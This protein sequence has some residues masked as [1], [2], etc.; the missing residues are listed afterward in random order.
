MQMKSNNNP[1]DIVNLGDITTYQA[2]VAQA[3]AHRVLK[4][5]TEDCLRPHGLTMMQWFILGTIHDASDKGITVT[6]LSKAVD[7]NVPY[8]TNTL[9]LLASKN[10]IS[11]D[12]N[13]EDSR[14]KRVSINPDY[15]PT[16]LAI[17]DDLRNKMREGIYARITPKEL[18]V[19]VSVLHKL[20][21]L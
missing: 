20:N 7:T 1:T 18:A 14:S 15:E 8:I 16:I 11:R 2:G 12:T 19:Y 3:T 13:E 9:N 21:H 17:E 4:K 5:F 10:I 6:Q